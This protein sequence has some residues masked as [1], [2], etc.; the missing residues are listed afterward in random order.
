MA[1]ITW[2][3]GTR[4]AGMRFV[5]S[6]RGGMDFSRLEVRSAEAFLQCLTNGIRALHRPKPKVD[7]GEPQQFQDAG[8][9]LQQCGCQ[10]IGAT[11]LTSGGPLRYPRGPICRSHQWRTR[12][13]YTG[14][15][16]AF[17]SLWILHGPPADFEED[18]VWY[19]HRESGTR[20]RYVFSHYKRFRKNQRVCRWSRSLSWAEIRAAA[21]KALP[22]RL[23]SERALKESEPPQPQTCPV[24]RAECETTRLS[25]VR[26]LDVHGVVHDV[27]DACVYC[28][29]RLREGEEF[30]IAT[31]EPYEDGDAWE[32][33]GWES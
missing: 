7:V 11:A 10:L 24:C 12:D 29:H 5:A 13:D 31:P 16:A 8:E 22:R 3:G 14:F 27:I 26:L 9:R 19:E 2:Y 25:S 28:A 21:R 33:P 1:R 6:D 4:D 18:G 30:T 32:T 20:I 15:A 23:E 17:D